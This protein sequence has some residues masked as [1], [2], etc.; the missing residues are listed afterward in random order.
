MAPSNSLAQA[1]KETR[2]NTWRDA[3]VLSQAHTVYLVRHSS[4][5][6]NRLIKLCYDTVVGSGKCIMW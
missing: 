4:L 3:R 6:A 2:D 5:N 1:L